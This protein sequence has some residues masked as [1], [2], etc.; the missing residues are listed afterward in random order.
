MKLE[1]TEPAVES[2]QAIKDY[3]ARDSEFYAA[4]F[5]EKIVGAAEKLADFP[6]L[7]RRVPEADRDDIREILFQTYRIIYRLRA[8]RVQILAVAHGGRD[9]ERV[10]T[11]PWE[12]G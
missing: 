5:T 3:I 9:L 10:E 6:N 12:V 1:W 4:R 11:K 8:E 2:L 7:G